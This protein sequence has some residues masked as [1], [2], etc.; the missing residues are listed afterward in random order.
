MDIEN[1]DKILSIIQI[2]KKK[3]E[4]IEKYIS[5]IPHLTR[6]NVIQEILQHIIKN[7]IIFTEIYSDY[8][9]LDRI[10]P[11]KKF[12]KVDNI[13]DNIILKIKEKP[14]KKIIL[15]NKFL[16]NFREISDNDKNVILDSL[17]DKD[18]EHIRETMVSIFKIFK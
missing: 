7:N 15:I 2:I 12:I 6:E 18:I 16:E 10:S 13:I 11:E 9:K 3:Q 17:K 4:E 14:S 1:I 5:E 8:I